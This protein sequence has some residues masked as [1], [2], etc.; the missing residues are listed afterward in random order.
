MRKPVIVRKL[1][2][3]WCAGYATPNPAEELDALE[4]LD[5]SGKLMQIAWEQVKWVCYVRELNPGDSIVPISGPRVL[6]GDTGNYAANPERLLRRRFSG[7]PRGAG[8]WLRI[9]LRD[10]DDLE[11]L[12][13]NDRSLVD[14]AGLLLTPP[15]TRSNTQRVFVPRSSIRE[16]IVLGV[17]NPSHTRS[18]THSEKPSLQPGLFEREHN[19]QPPE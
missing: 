14:G 3:D 6:A 11:G 1:T 5:I 8:L 17:I 10:G 13:A 2:R 15:D 4:L 18:Q 12:A 7:R 16:L 9:T 19:D